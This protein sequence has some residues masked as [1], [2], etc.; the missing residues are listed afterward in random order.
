MIKR[1]GVLGFDAAAA[2]AAFVLALVVRYDG[3]TQ[4]VLPLL[5]YAV[6]YALISLTVFWSFGLHRSVWR[7]TATPDMLRLLKAVTVSL[8]IGG[9][10]LFIFTRLENFPRSALIIL[11]ML[12]MVLSLSPRVLIRLVFEKSEAQTPTNTR[13]KAFLIG[14]GPAADR[15]IKESLR[16]HSDFKIAGIIADEH[17]KGRLIHGIPVLG[18]LVHLPSLMEKHKKENIELFILT[19]KYHAL[20][21]IIL[22]TA[23]RHDITLRRIPD[24]DTMA[25][26]DSLTNLKPVLIEDLLG[27]TPKNL[28]LASITSLVEK[29]DVLI[30][31]A[32]GSIGA[33]LCRQVALN[34][35]KSLVLVDNC[36]YALY[37]IE[38]ELV[39]KHPKLALHAILLDVKDKDDLEQVFKTFKPKVVIHAAAYKH[40]PLV[41]ANPVAGVANNLLGTCNV[42]DMA[43]KYQAGT[44]LIISTDKAVN[45]TNVMG[46][47]KRAAE[48][49]CQ[50][51]N[52]ATRFVTVRFGNVLGSTGSVV[53]LF[54]QQIKQGGPVTVTHKE[55]RRYFMTIPEAVQLTLQAAAL[56]SKSKD[57]DIYMLDMGEAIRIWDLAE[58]M[59]KLSGLV[60]QVDIQIQEVGLRPGEKLFEELSYNAEEMATTDV[61]EIFLVK[62]AKTDFSA[63]Q[64]H[65]DAIAA[66]CDKKDVSGVIDLLQKMVPEYAPAANS[67]YTKK[68]KAP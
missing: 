24:M 5:P 54:T 36:E 22:Q 66:K 45:P 52:S 19:E 26:G 51:L 41:E 18:N 55:A 13:K 15:F 21:D 14:A 32:G 7:Y 49:Y 57:G 12:H 9:F 64:K 44:M 42:A 65:L 34:G 29:K 43:D 46:A 63:Y 8:L 50:N 61:D 33:E 47:T 67:P 37:T 60:P 25:E 1:L 53:P 62:A 17:E 20:S 4:S 2:A 30:T 56:G 35:A 59:I 16:H 58:E 28:Q 23:H 38:R 10:V 31:G 40:V 11:W 6:P 68:E 27:R 48:I 3:L 39:K